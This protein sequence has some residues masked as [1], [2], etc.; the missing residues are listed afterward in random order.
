MGG[1]AL[2]ICP[3]GLHQVVGGGD[4]VGERVGLGQLLAVVVPLTAQ[5]TAAA[6]MGDREHHPAV[7]QAQPRDAEGWVH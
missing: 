4:E 1:N 2:R 3:P 5:F 7:Q 6:H